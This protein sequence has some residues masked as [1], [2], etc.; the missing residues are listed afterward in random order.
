[1]IKELGTRSLPYEWCDGASKCEMAYTYVCLAGADPEK[2]LTVFDMKAS[3]VKVILWG[4][5]V[6]PP[7]NILITPFE[8]T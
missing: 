1:M 7:K 2:I 3:E 5:G 8:L 6:S 4:S